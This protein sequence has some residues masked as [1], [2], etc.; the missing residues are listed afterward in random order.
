M[1]HHGG[2][3]CELCILLA[4]YKGLNIIGGDHMYDDH[5]L[6]SIRAFGTYSAQEESDKM[7]H[8]QNATRLVL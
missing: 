1:T 3:V 7:L 4:F 5:L 6:S 2:D 8:A